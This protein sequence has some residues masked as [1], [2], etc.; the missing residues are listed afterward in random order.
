MRVNVDQMFDLI[1]AVS[2]HEIYWKNG[3]HQNGIW[4]D[5]NKIRYIEFFGPKEKGVVNEKIGKSAQKIL[6]Y[7]EYNSAGER[8]TEQD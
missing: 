7:S 5:I 2:N 6:I 4:I 1:D 3:V 8:T